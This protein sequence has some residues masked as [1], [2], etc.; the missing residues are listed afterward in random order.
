MSKFALPCV[1]CGKPLE[2]VE[3]GDDNQP[4]GGTEF[5]TYGHY[6]STIHDEIALSEEEARARMALVV[7]ICDTCILR[8]IDA[9]VIQSR[10]ENI[11]LSRHPISDKARAWVLAQNY[12]HY[13]S[14]YGEDEN[15]DYE[16]LMRKAGWPEHLIREEDSP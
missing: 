7:N 6:G 3:L 13:G 2:N 8:A 9:G 16:D 1:K 5:I 15:V 14:A 10:S 4:A 12:K 11:R